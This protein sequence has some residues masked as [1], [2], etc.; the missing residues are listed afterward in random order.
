MSLTLGGHQCHF[1]LG[2]GLEPLHRL[3][4]M[5]IFGIPGW[6]AWLFASCQL[7]NRSSIMVPWM[8]KV[9]EITVREVWNKGNGDGSKYFRYFFIFVGEQRKPIMTLNLGCF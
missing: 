7:R 8:A 1:D 6:S 5:I 9:L 4:L 2:L 3:C